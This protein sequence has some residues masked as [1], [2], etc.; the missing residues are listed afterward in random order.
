MELKGKIS[1]IIGAV[2]DVTF[3]DGDNLPFDTLAVAVVTP[4]RMTR[5][6]NPHMMII[7]KVYD[8]FIFHEVLSAPSSGVKHFLTDLE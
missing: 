4:P 3:A 6:V 8:D 2:V 7:M 1:Q 5:N